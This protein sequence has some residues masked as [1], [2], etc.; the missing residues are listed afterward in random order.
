MPSLRTSAAILAAAL[1]SM[2][3]NSQAVYTI[4]PDSVSLPTRQGWCS[5][6]TASCPLLC[7][8]LS[9]ES[10]T[11][12]ANDC[13]PE[14]LS[15]ECICGNGLSPNASEYSQTL[16]YF[17]CQEYGN[18]C[19][20]RAMAT[21]H[22]KVLAEPI[23]HAEPKTPPESTS[24]AVLPL[25]PPMSQLVQQLVQEERLSTTDLEAMPEPQQLPLVLSLLAQTPSRMVHKWHW[26]LA[27]ATASLLCSLVFSPDLLWSCRTTSSSV[28]FDRFVVSSGLIL[29]PQVSTTH[30]CVC[31]AMYL[32]CI[33]S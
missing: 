16:P 1:F 15:Y 4:N 33:W 12:A 2:S 17:E 21:H 31:L 18:Q 6:Q 22:A 23:I 10:S 19:W 9:G 7:L 11:T 27:A 20:Q 30:T 28:L 5:S 24:Q 3:V 29:K 26:T 14:A 32:E 13:D 8:Q 25:L